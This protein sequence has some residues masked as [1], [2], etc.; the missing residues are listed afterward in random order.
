MPLIGPRLK[1]NL[2]GKMNIGHFRSSIG[3]KLF[4]PTVEEDLQMVAQPSLHDTMRHSQPQVL[5][6]NNVRRNTDHRFS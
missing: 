1:A 6:V 3:A 5:G 2:K 4:R